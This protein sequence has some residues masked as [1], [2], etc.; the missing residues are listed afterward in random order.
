MSF[1]QEIA[2]KENREQYN[3]LKSDAETINSQLARWVGTYDSLK[4]KVDT[5]K[6]S[7]LD[8]KKAQ[9]IQTLRTT[10]GI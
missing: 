7:E 8:A 2:S 10:L 3:Q 1:E 6:Q 4:L 9:F 5:T